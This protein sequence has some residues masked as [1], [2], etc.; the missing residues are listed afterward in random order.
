MDDVDGSQ[1][2]SVDLDAE[3]DDQDKHEGTKAQQDPSG[4]QAS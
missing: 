3:N 4:H 2:L 1:E